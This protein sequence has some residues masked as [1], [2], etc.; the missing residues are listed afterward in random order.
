MAL[1]TLTCG[2][3][4]GF[5]GRFGL[6]RVE[7]PPELLRIRPNFSSQYLY[8]ETLWIIMLVSSTRVQQLLKGAAKRKGELNVEE[9]LHPMS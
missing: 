5:H 7:R 9:M 3:W 8:L 2:G 6:R 1:T 4:V